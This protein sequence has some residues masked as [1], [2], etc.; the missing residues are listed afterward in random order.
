GG[1]GD[2]GGRADHQRTLPRGLGAQRV[3]RRSASRPP[4]F[5]PCSRCTPG[6]I[7]RVRDADLGQALT[8]VVEGPFQVPVPARH[9][10]WVRIC[11]W[12][13]TASIFPL[14]FTGFVILMAHPRLYW[15]D[16]G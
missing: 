1:A 14:A 9:A 5:R 8:E 16:V 3:A 10:W 7:M 6:D 2:P 11:H 13:A 4:L 12:T 15:G